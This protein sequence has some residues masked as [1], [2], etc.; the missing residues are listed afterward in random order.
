L[1][2]TFAAIY[3][4]PKTLKNCSMKNFDF[5][6][7]RTTNNRN[8]TILTQVVVIA[9]F[10][11]VGLLAMVIL[12]IPGDNTSRLESAKW[13]FNAIVPLVASWVGAVI[14]FYFGRDNYEAATEQV[15][16]L[17]R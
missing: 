9:G 1:E 7:T 10:I 17:T 5:S 4:Y 13:V 14:A 8:R 2:L 6:S 15:L 11:L 16:A 3:F 12:V